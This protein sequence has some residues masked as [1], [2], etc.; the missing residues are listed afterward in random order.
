MKTAL[1]LS[2]GAPHAW[3]TKVR[4]EG[5][6]IPGISAVEERNLVD[7]D[8]RA[9]QQSK[10]VIESAFVYFLT[11][12]D[13]ITPEGSAALSSLEEGLRRCETAAEQLEEAVVL[14]IDGF[15]DSVAD[16]AKNADLSER[17]AQKVRDFLLLCGFD[18]VRLLAVGMGTPASVPLGDA[19]IPK[20]VEGYVAF[21]VSS[22][23]V[24]L[25]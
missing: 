10:S 15:A 9:F 2:G 3:L 16:M 20:Q 18:S 5:T 19:A 7:L 8:Q 25:P 11:D 13:E 23:R 1:I 6:S 21:K 12:K 4:S 14:E 17:R 24:L 22:S